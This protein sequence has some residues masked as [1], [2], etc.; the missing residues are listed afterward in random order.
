MTFVKD[1]YEKKMHF[2]QNK[3]NNSIIVHFALKIIRAM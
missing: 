1:F 3:I 2:R